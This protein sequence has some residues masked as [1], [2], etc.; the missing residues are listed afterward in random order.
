[1]TSPLELAGETVPVAGASRGVGRGAA[2]EISRLGATVYATGRTIDD[3]DLPDGVRGLRCDHN[4]DDAVSEVFERVARE[5]DEL[6]AGL[7]VS[8]SESP[9]FTG[10]HPKR[11]VPMS[12][13]R[14]T[15]PGRLRARPP[16]V[17]AC[18]LPLAALACAPG[19]RGP[20]GI[21]IDTVDGVVRLTN[22]AVP[23]D[24]PVAG[25]LLPD[26]LRIGR[27]DGDGPDVF[28]EIAAL[29]VGPDR[30]VYVADGAALEVRVF[31]PAG[32]FL[33]AFGA[34]GEGPGEFE[35][36]DG[37]SV[38]PHGRVRVRDPRLGRVSVFGADGTFEDSFRLERSFL[39]FSDGTEFWSDSAGRVYD[40]IV[41]GLGAD[42]PDRSAAVVYADGAV[43]DTVVLVEH[44]PRRTF[45]RQGERIVLGMTVPFGPRPLIAVSPTGEIA[46]GL[47][48]A[49]RIAV[50][51][52]SGDTLRLFAR[53]VEPDPVTDPD[54][55]AAL[56]G[57]RARAREMAPGAVLDEVDLPDTKPFISE[58]RALDGG[59][60]WVGRYR[61]EYSADDPTSPN[62]TEWDEFDAEGRYLGTVT[63]PPILVFGVGRDYVAGVETDDLGVEYAVVYDVARSGVDDVGGP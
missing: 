32:E 16:L 17:P 19:D 34:K 22:L 54:A 43:A 49:Y 15:A 28:G 51:D 13:H 50:T 46:A 21:A 48:D 44:T 55:E 60:W 31:S 7:D 41:L 26:P 5:R 6:A 40:R 20:E 4:D 37:L 36:I 52:A 35:A 14:S 1:M 25:R 63:T 42:G 24:A 9:E 61:G 58:I 39:I 29:A 53:A 45:A 33:R 62:P 57:M 23:G 3:A 2:A 30:D 56:D 27:V 47:G 38:G 18:L 10:M 59:G 12:G 8:R 11:G